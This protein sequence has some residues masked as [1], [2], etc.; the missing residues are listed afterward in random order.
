[1]LASIGMGAQRGLLIK[2]GKYLELLARADVLLIDKTGTV[3]LGRPQIT[4]ILP[5]DDRTPDDLLRLA[6]SCERYSEHPLAEAVRREAVCDG[7][8]PAL[9]VNF[10]VLPGLGVRAQIEGAAVV[11]GNTHLIPQA[12]TEVRVRALQEQGKTL[13]CVMKDRV[14]IGVLAAADTLRPD[15]QAALERVRTLGVQRIELLTGD[16]EQTARALASSLGIDYRAHLL[17]ADKL[18]V[19][20]AYQAQGH[21]VVMV[22][23]GINDAPALAQADIGIAMG[24]KG[25]EVA[26]DA[27]H[28]ALLRDD[29][30][31]V[32]DAFAIAHRTMRVVKLNLG[33]TVLY[34]LVGLSLAALGLLPPLV[35]AA[36][37]SLP[38]L[39]ILANS[40]Q[41]LRQNA[42]T[43]KR[44]P[45][46]NQP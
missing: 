8:T 46:G 40:A 34:N 19:V 30:G 31:L 24:V 5:L 25:T 21:R 28:L 1:M 20:K 2:G 23:D 3:T 36:A 13:L 6:A 29:W 41:L 17:P 42:R 44:T 22:G 16:H 7:L 14:L 12:T 15:V 37:Q 39:G 11:V 18:D 35:A 26:L 27:A 38:D 45:E 9:P 4:D 43:S 33:F 10:E 32:P